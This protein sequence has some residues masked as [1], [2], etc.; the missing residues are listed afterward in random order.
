MC[1]ATSSPVLHKSPTILAFSALAEAFSGEWHMGAASRWMASAACNLVRTWLGRGRKYHLNH[2]VASICRLFFEP[3]PALLRTGPP[4]VAT[5]PAG[6]CDI[7]RQEGTT[8]EPWPTLLLTHFWLMM[9]WFFN[10]GPLL[11]PGTAILSA[12]SRASSLP[13]VSCHRGRVRIFLRASLDGRG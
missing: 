4:D 6:W 12:R 9:R 11:L 13:S 7:W 3:S 8:P 2:A 1:L 10:A 5:K